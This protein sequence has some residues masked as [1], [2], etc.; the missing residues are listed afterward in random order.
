MPV[1]VEEK[2]SVK[3]GQWIRNIVFLILLLGGLSL[4]GWLAP[5]AGPGFNPYSNSPQS[6]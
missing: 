2:R 5:S 6:R 3:K 1:L 4:A